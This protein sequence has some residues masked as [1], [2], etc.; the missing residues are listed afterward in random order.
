MMGFMKFLR[1]EDNCPLQGEEPKRCKKSLHNVLDYFCGG[2]YKT[3]WV[4]C[5]VEFL[6]IARKSVLRKNSVCSNAHVETA[7]FKN[8]GEW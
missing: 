8:L 7:L 3:E 2:C 5:R 1:L 6:L 4:L